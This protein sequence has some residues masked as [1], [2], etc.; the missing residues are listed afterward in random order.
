MTPPFQGRSTPS[1]PPWPPASP[2]CRCTC[3]GST[4]AAS[5]GFPRAV[6]GCPGSSTT[7][8]LRSRRRRSTWCA[9]CF[10]PDAVFESGDTRLQ[11]LDAISGYYTSKTFTFDDFRPVPGVPNFDGTRVHVDIDVD[12]GGAQN[13]VHDLFETDGTRITALRVSGFEEALRS[14]ER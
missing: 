4:L 3:S 1:A 12:L 9:R 10:T 7:T 13:S 5:T 6:P 2:Q 14:A 8:S 11:G